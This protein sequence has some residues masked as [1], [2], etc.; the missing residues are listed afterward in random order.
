MSA[1]LT[2]PEEMSREELEE[3]VRESRRLREE[4][5]ELRVELKEEVRQSQESREEVEELRDE[6]QSAKREMGRMNALQAQINTM[7]KMLAGDPEEFSMIDPEEMT[8]IKDRL[9]DVEE[10][11]NAHG[12]KFEMF[13]VEEGKKSTPDERA[14]HLRQVLHNNAKSNDGKA[15]IDRDAARA[16]LGGD[17]HRGSVLDAMRR[18]ADGSDAEINGSSDLQ[19]I[20]GFVFTPG[21][22]RD[23]QSK[24]ALDLTQFD[25]VD[26]RKNLTTKD[27]N[28][29][30]SR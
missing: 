14:M 4:V 8:P 3:E 19:P 13:V 2:A 15:R 27:T 11:A 23:T 16:A 9:E 6:L 24:V 29:G 21:E 26:L 18:A 10:T 5:E 25:P 1:D 30:G 17:L 12:E 22:H 28:N 20:D 7:K